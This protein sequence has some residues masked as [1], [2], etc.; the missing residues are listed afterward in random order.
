MHTMGEER[1]TFVGLGWENE[2]RNLGKPDVPFI[3]SSERDIRARN[4]CSDNYDLT[5]F[6]QST[7][8]RR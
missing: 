7:Q 6:S 2:I 8:A 4:Q 5:P 1:K 3:P